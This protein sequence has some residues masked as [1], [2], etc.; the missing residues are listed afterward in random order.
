MVEVLRNRGIQFPFILFVDNYKGHI[1]EEAS[2]YC[3]LNDVILYGLEKNTTFV[4][5]P[6]DHNVF[7]PMKQAW[8]T[9]I[10]EWQEENEMEPVT[11]KRFPELFRPVWEKF[12]A[13]P[14]RFK[15]AFRDC[16]LFPW[17]PDIVAYD[18]LQKLPKEVQE[19]VQ[20]DKEA[21]ALAAR[22]KAP[23]ATVTP[24][25]ST[26]SKVTYESFDVTIA[27]KEDGTAQVYLP[28]EEA[29]HAPTMVAGL[30]RRGYNV[31][32]HTVSGKKNYFQK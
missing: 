30:R 2:L 16:G 26:K 1:S 8:K 29:R 28:L 11:F 22:Q 10:E 23:T 9:R 15:K 18:R 32:G 24:S 6:L 20:M 17:N 7:G 21:R 25:T 12:A 27:H 13:Q 14:E 19:L 31:V 3:H 5:Q 4:Y